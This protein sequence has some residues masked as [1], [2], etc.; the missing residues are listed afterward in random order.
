MKSTPAARANEPAIPREEADQPPAAA[1]ETTPRQLSRDDYV[2]PPSATVGSVRSLDNRR[3]SNRGSEERKRTQQPRTPVINLASVPKSSTPLPPP[4]SREP[5]PQK[6]EIRFTKDDISGQRQG[7]KAAPIEQFE[8]Q[9][10]QDKEDAKRRDARGRGPQAEGGLKG[11]AKAA[12]DRKGRHRP[13]EEEEDESK[14]GKKGASGIVAARAERRKRQLALDE[15]ERRQ[16][17]G[18]RKLIRKGTNTAAPRKEQ[19]VLELPCTI[20]SFSEAAGVPSGRVLASLMQLGHLLNINAN[21]DRELGELLAVELGI[22]IQFKQPESL[23]VNL[24]QQLEQ[25]QDASES[26]APDR[27]S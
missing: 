12:A 18:S 22:A 9:Q 20:R 25:Q 2:A 6:P 1:A 24:S 13:G 15:D 5:A 4:K 11:F 10:K 8:A 3:S 21:I 23:D 7:M 14:S 17:S 16:R 26:L 19:V 27:P